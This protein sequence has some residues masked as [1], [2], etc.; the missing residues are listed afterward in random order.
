MYSVVV[1]IGRGSHSLRVVKVNGMKIAV[2]GG[3][4]KNTYITSNLRVRKD[5]EVR[6]IRHYWFDTWPDHGGTLNAVSDLKV[7]GTLTHLVSQTVP[8]DAAP[9]ASMLK[10]VREWSNHPD[11]PWIVHCSA[12]IG[13]TG[14]FIAI[15]QGM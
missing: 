10:A 9:V 15:D 1:Q 11:R 8:K 13:R 14:T 12:G 5:G 4:R 6:E 3:Y 7:D 2:M